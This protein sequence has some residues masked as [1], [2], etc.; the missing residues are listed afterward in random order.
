MSIELHP[1]RL[2]GTPLGHHHP[3]EEPFGGPAPP[4]G[5]KS[6]RSI[7]GGL[8]GAAAGRAPRPAQGR[9]PGRGAKLPSVPKIGAPHRRR[10][11]PDRGALYSRSLE[12]PHLIIIQYRA[13]LKGG[14]Q[15][16]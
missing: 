11:L 13:Q 9:P 15:L 5:L 4:P 8:S 12:G 7:S 1:R 14:P 16:A 6:S 10:Q 3:P 2:T